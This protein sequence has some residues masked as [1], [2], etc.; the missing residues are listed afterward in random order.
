M[1]TNVILKR[2]AVPGKTP[3]TAQLNLGE[4][5]INTN[6]GKLFFKQDDGVTESLVT[7]IEVTENN[8]T[9]DPSTLNYSS[10]T[11]L[12]G[13]LN[14]IDQKVKDLEDEAHI[15]LVNH[16]T[17]LSGDGTSVSPLSVNYTTLDGRYLQA[18]SDTLQSVTDRGASTTNEITLPSI[19]FDTTVTAASAS[20]GQLVWNSDDGTLTLGMAG[21]NVNLQ[22]GQ[23]FLIYVYNNSAAPITNGQV[24]Y[25]T[26]ASGNRIT[27]AIADNTTEASSD[28][29]IGVATEDIGI[30]A[31][32]Y[33]TKTGIVRGLNTSSFT[34]GDVIYLG[35]NGDITNVLPDSPN[36]E[37]IVG[38]VIKVD[39]TDGHIFVN[40]NSGWE[41]GELHDVKITSVADNDILSWDSTSGLWINTSG[42]EHKWVDY[43]PI[44]YHIDPIP[45]KEGR[46]FY[47]EE[48]RT[49][50]MYSDI[51]DVSLQLGQEEWVRVYNGTASTILNGTPCRPT[52]AFGEMQSVAPA[53]AQTKGGARVL[54][55]ATHDI[56]AGT[57]GYLTVRGLVSGLDT[58]GLTAGAPL[59]LGVNGELT[60]TVPTYP[61]YPTQVGGCIVSNATNGY[62]YVNPRYETIDQLRVIANGH[63]DGSLT[64]D[65]DLIV[66]GTQ[67]IVTQNNLAISDSFI[68]LNSGDTI[69][70]AGTT[71]TGT[72][73]NDAYFNNYYEGTTTTTYY[74]RIDGVGTGTGGVDT[75]EWSKD[76]FATTIATGVDLADN[77]LL[78]NNICIHFNALTGHTL[79]DVWSGTA[80]PV[81][82]DSGW[83]TNRNTGTTGIG[84]THMGIFFDVSDEKFKVFDQYG[85]EPTGT[86]DTGDATFNLGTIVAANFEGLATDSNKLNNQLPSY[87]LNY[88]N[89]T[90][91]PTIGNAT[92]TLTAGDGLGTGGSFTT[93]ASTASEITFTNTDKGS[94]QNI[95]KTISVT[96]QT[97]IEAESNTQN[98]EL[99][100][101]T[102]VTITT[103]AI[104]KQITFTTANDNDN[105]FLTGLSFDTATGVL[106]ATVQNQ[107]DVTVDLD[108]RYVLLSDYPVGTSSATASTTN[109]TVVDTFDKTVYRTA[110]YLVQA[111]YQ[112]QF[113]S[114]EILLIHNDVDVFISQY[115][116]VFTNAALATFDA[117]INNGNVELICT[118]VNAGTDINVHR[119]N[120]GV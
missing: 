111:T 38:W 116:S 88:N 110:K 17:T 47:N 37:V 68:Y 94:S 11:T 109:P 67:S 15:S 9:I 31:S 66:N 104:N 53:N 46:L 91:T 10:S 22:V 12:A 28:S 61:Y 44:D 84:Y 43:T 39:V 51:T 45:H 107:L 29:S 102:N 6:D 18:E 32:G 13:V 90:N 41:I 89:F 7:I 76:N 27:V 74:V 58:S 24:V 108:D 101:G 19:Q 70:L 112:T 62:I 98:L 79:G 16:D 105:D 57:T 99:I 56:P 2:S 40:I 80:S 118:A 1:S 86:I 26:G 54:G 60:H 78:D 117:Q 75:F 119:I 113:H 72:G 49:L 21:G 106:T 114:A 23:E 69:G 103:D 3:T 42:P 120:I 36:H 96:G 48:Y 63:V 65:G 95:F 100:A 73:L 59:F 71:F 35:T 8:L 82:I 115:G 5:A 33:I 55:V 77:V 97:T 87:Y 92:I 4:I 30:G 50:T 85:P 93:N 20:E 25:I 81:N 34:E 14:D 64:I 83:A 52:G